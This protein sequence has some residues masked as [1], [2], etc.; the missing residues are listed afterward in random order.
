MYIILNLDV[1]VPRV[2]QNQLKFVMYTLCLLDNG[3]HLFPFNF[4][5]IFSQLRGNLF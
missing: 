3:T 4:E 2:V 5:I 1:R